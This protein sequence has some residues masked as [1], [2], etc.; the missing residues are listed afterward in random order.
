MSLT[1]ASRGMLQATAQL[2]DRLSTAG[3]SAPSYSARA[4]VNFNGV[5]LTGTY[6]QSGTLV[7]VTITTHGMETGMIANV[8]PT[9]GTGVAYNDRAITKTGTNTYT[10]M[11]GASLTT[12]GNI[13]QNLY[14][15]AAGNVSSITDNG[16][17]DYTVNFTSPMSDV[18]YSLMGVTNEAVIGNRS[19][20]W[21]IRGVDASFITTSSVRIDVGSQSSGGEFD[22]TVVTAVIFR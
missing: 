22:L 8:T 10:Y 19:T 20:G 18:Y 2:L 21:C 9:S 7:T 17:G 6:S 16:V 15:R 5:P 13:T 3:G 14:I 12:S 11:A 4:W 1:K